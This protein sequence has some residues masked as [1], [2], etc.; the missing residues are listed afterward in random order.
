MD[1]HLCRTKLVQAHRIPGNEEAVWVMTS[2]GAKQINLESKSGHCW[3]ITPVGMTEILR[4]C[5]AL[6][7]WHISAKGIKTMLLILPLKTVSLK[8]IEIFLATFL[9]SSALEGVSTHRFLSIKEQKNVCNIEAGGAVDPSQVIRLS[10]H[11]W[12]CYTVFGNY[13]YA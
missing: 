1:T 6:V 3:L 13:F 9:K 2:C 12:K 10:L 5:A 11:K 7:Q 4:L 8:C